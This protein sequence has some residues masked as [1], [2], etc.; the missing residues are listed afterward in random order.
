MKPEE[1]AAYIGAAAWVPVVIAWLNRVFTKPKLRIV[2]DQQFE[3]GFTSLGPIF[4]LRLALFVEN[5]AIVIDDVKF[6]VRHSDGETHTF[7]WAGIAEKF[8]E[9]HDIG[10]GRKQIISR[11]QTPIAI[12]VFTQSV[13]EKSLRFLDLKYIEADKTVGAPL[14]DQFAFLKAQHPDTYVAQAL[15]SQELHNFIASRQ[16]FFGWKPGTYT[17]TM[18]IS[19]PQRFKFKVDTFSFSLSASDVILLKQNINFIDVDMKNTINSN[20]PGSVATEFQWQWVNP[21]IERTK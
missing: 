1:I 11:D 9:I 15:A 8:S 16:A 3:L 21:K 4:N 2:P 20:T 6:E 5:R 10:S 13:F 7:S 12:K 17:V 19:S 14:L 18:K